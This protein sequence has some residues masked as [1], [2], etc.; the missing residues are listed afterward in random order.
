MWQ[1]SEFTN[2]TSF[3]RACCITNIL[4]TILI[5]QGGATPDILSGHPCSL[6]V[7]PFQY[8]MTTCWGDP[9]DILPASRTA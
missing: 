4:Q 7:T 5:Y 8:L 3:T 6:D 2:S 1:S 9:S